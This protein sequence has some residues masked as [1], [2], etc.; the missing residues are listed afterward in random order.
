MPFF[1]LG[2]SLVAG[3]A[4]SAYLGFNS[5]FWMVLFICFTALAVI[6]NLYCDHANH[7]LLS[8]RLYS[9]LFSLLATAFALGGW[10]IQSVLSEWS[11]DDPTGYFADEDVTIHAMVVSY[12]RQ[13]QSGL[14]AVVRTEKIEYTGDVNTY[15]SKIDIR[16][17]AG[18]HL[19]YGDRVQLVG[20]LDPVLEPGQAPYESYLAINGISSR[21][22]YPQIETTAR[23]K[24]GLI[25]A[26][27]YRLRTAGQRV[28][29]DQMPYP[30]SALV[31][32]ILLGIDWNIPDFLQEAYRATGTIHIIAISG[33][34]IALIAGL[35]ARLFRRVFPLYW[36]GIFSVT[37]I[38]VYTIL[39]GADPAVVRAA[40]MG[41]AAIPAYYIGRRV[42]GV[43]SLSIA[44]AAMLFF[45]PLLLWNIGFQ[46]SFLATLGLMTLADPLTDWLQTG[47]EN[48]V[49]EKTAAI[50]RPLVVLTASTLAA[51]FA[52]SP[53]LLKLDPSLQ[54]FS[55][56]A[57]LIILP[58]QPLLMGSGG[59]GL[60][61]GFIF[62]PLGAL[63]GRIAWLMAA[64]SNRT[65]IYFSLN[66][67][68][69][70][71]LPANTWIPSGLIVSIVFII[72]TRNQIKSMGK[73]NQPNRT[74]HS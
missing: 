25:K 73:I 27:I 16:L 67:I 39:V 59:I 53:V 48:R 14:S 63:F 46:L 9:T 58:L 37:A 70:M 31:S 71:K 7:P 47:I 3:T 18:F 12:P 33:F 43:N 24:G 68:A 20:K 50:S 52:V 11:G 55:L 64:I 40:V 8:R 38:C 45:N 54:I 13:S 57:N 15:N 44:A 32:G 34:N 51:Q 19:A 49:S 61:A 72:F 21:M 23:D 56:P 65:A 10:R 28:I 6:E 17:P 69:E 22:N 60:L 30:E 26:A 29:Y 36:D 5:T 1:W 74:N 4:I 62:P 66:P 2:L 35:V 41:A 42:I